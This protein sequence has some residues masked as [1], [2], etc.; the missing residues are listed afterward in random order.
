MAKQMTSKQ[1]ET[2]K[3]KVVDYAARMVE[4]FNVEEAAARV[5]R[6]YGCPTEIKNGKLV[7]WFCRQSVT[8]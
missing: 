1:I 2:W 3:N 8:L 6:Y 4:K 7:I 5:W